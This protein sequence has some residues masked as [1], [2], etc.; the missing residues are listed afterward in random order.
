MDAKKKLSENINGM[1]IKGKTRE[2]ILRKRMMRKKAMSV[3]M[4]KNVGAVI[5]KGYLMKNSL[6]R[7][8]K[9]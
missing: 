9:S 4:R 5:F 8:R 1:I 6:Q 7:S 3:P 2:K